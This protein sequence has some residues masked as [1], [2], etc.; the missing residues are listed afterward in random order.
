MIGGL[1][2]CGNS[3]LLRRRRIKALL[4][5]KAIDRVQGLLKA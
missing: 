3:R 1:S 2:G 4:E 5:A